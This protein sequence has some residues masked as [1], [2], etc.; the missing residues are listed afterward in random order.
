MNFH[1]ERGPRYPTQYRC[2]LPREAIPHLHFGRGV[3]TEKIE[4]RGILAN[5][6]IRA[7]GAH[8]SHHLSVTRINSFRRKVIPQ[9]A[10]Y[11]R[12]PITATRNIAA[13]C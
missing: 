6:L 13:F 5:G 7:T 12:G 3:L 4:F 8:K 11:L 2:D 10:L 1:G 9:D